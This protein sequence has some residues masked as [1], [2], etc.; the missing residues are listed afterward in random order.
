MALAKIAL[1]PEK[2]GRGKPSK[3][4]EGFEGGDSKA[5]REAIYKARLV[6]HVTPAVADRVLAGTLAPR[7]RLRYRDSRKKALV[8]IAFQL[9]MISCV[10]GAGFSLIVGTNTGF[11]GSAGGISMFVTLRRR[12]C[13]SLRQISCQ[14]SLQARGLTQRQIAEKLGVT[15]K[16][17]ANWLSNFG[18]APELLN[19]PELPDAATLDAIAQAIKDD[20][21]HSRRR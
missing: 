5:M 2:G 16:T 4:L 21:S 12:G 3:I 9:R 7:R 15:Q 8:S 11:S 17:V 19:E 20:A 14:E 10:S 6:L 13:I 18:T 1:E